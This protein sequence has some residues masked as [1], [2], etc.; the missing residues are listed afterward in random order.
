MGGE[1][2]SDLRIWQE[3]FDERVGQAETQKNIFI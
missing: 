3:I 1:L 2:M